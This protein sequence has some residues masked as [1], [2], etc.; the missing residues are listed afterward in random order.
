DAWLVR[1]DRCL[2]RREGHCFAILGGQRPITRRMVRCDLRRI[3]AAPLLG[4]APRRSALRENRGLSRTKGSGALQIGSKQ[5][6]LPALFE[7]RVGPHAHS[8]WI[9]R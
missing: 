5:R 1:D 4:P 8:T 3:K 7:L 6:D 9:P 2:G